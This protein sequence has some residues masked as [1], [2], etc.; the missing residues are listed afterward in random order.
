M[1]E[2]IERIIQES[3]EDNIPLDQINELYLDGFKAKDF[4][5]FPN[6][7]PNVK[8]LSANLCKLRNLDGFPSL[9]HLVNLS[10]ADN[11]IRDITG[12]K[13]CPNIEY[14]YLAGNKKINTLEQ[15]EILKDFPNLHLLDLSDDIW[16]SRIQEV[17]DYLPQIKVCCCENREGLVMDIFADSENELDDK[18]A[19]EDVIHEQEL[20]K[21]EQIDE[22]AD[23]LNNDDDDE[24][25]EEEP[26]KKEP[27][28]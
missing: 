4:T 3:K 16:T 22:L 17:F 20:A 7:F 9:K 28:E 27:I 15:L 12:L 25:K 23:F 11:R 6:V 24:K 26:F 5:D 8:V 13:S 2:E 1:Q 10:L 19:E 14:L 21:N 18:Q